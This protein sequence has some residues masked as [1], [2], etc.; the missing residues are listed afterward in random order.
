M[1]SVDQHA[2]SSSSS[3]FGECE[4][5]IQILQLIHHHQQQRSGEEHQPE[6]GRQKVAA[7]ARQRMQLKQRLQQAQ[8]GRKSQMQI[9]DENLSTEAGSLFPTLN[10]RFLPSANGGGGDR[11]GLALLERDPLLQRASGGFRLFVHKFTDQQLLKCMRTPALNTLRQWAPAN[12]RYIHVFRNAWK[13]LTQFERLDWQERFEHYAKNGQIASILPG[14][15][16]DANAAL[17][18]EGTSSSSSCKEDEQRLRQFQWLSTVDADNL[19]CPLCTFE[20]PRRYKIGELLAHLS[21]SH[22]SAHLYACHCCSR[23]FTRVEA[24]KEHGVS[25]QCRAFLRFMR[26]NVRKM[27]DEVRIDDVILLNMT[28]HLFLKLIFDFAYASLT[29]A[30]CG[31]HLLLSPRGDQD[32]LAETLLNITLSHSS[33]SLALCLTFASVELT[34]PFVHLKFLR[35]VVFESVYKCEFCLRSGCWSTPME[36]E[37]HCATEHRGAKNIDALHKCPECS[38]TFYTAPLFCDHLLSEHLRPDVGALLITQFLRT[39]PQLPPALDK[40]GTVLVGTVGVRRVSSH[41]NA[42][43]ATNPLKWVPAAERAAREGELRRSKRKRKR[44]RVHTPAPDEEEGGEAEDDDDDDEDE[45]DDDWDE[46]ELLEAKKKCRSAGG[47][48]TPLTSSS[49]CSL[50]AALSS[51]FGHWKTKMRQLEEKAFSADGGPLAKFVAR[52]ALPVQFISG[53]IIAHNPLEGALLTESVYQCVKCSA[54][55]SGESAVTEHIIVCHQIEKNGAGHAGA[56]DDYEQLLNEYVFD[57]VEMLFVAGNFPFTRIRCDLCSTN[58]CSIPSLRRHYAQCH[59]ILCAFQ[60]NQSTI[61]ECAAVLLRRDWANTGFDRELLQ[62]I[63]SSQPPKCTSEFESECDGNANLHQL[64]AVKLSATTLYTSLLHLVEQ[65]QQQPKEQQQE[66]QRLEVDADDDAGVG[67]IVMDVKEEPME[68]EEWEQEHQQHQKLVIDEQQSEAGQT[69]TSSSFDKKLLDDAS[70]F[71][72]ALVKDELIEQHEEQESSECFL[73]MSKDNDDGDVGDLS[74]LVVKDE[75]MNPASSPSSHAT[76]ADLLQRSDDIDSDCQAD[77]EDLV[78]HDHPL[79]QNKKRGRKK[80]ETGQGLADGGRHDQADHVHE[81]HNAYEQQQLADQVDVGDRRRPTKEPVKWCCSPIKRGRKKGTGTTG[82]R[83]RPRKLVA[84]VPGVD[85]KTM[86]MM[87]TKNTKTTTA[88]RKSAGGKRGRKKKKKAIDDDEWMTATAR[89]KR[90]YTKRKPKVATFIDEK[91]VEDKVGTVAAGTASCTVATEAQKVHEEGK[92]GKLNEVETIM[93]GMERHFHRKRGRPAKKKGATTEQQGP[94]TSSSTSTAVVIPSSSNFVCFMCTAV[95]KNFDAFGRHLRLH[96]EQWRRC[97]ICTDRRKN[98]VEVEKEAEA[99]AEQQQQDKEEED[100]SSNKHPKQRQR[101]YFDHPVQ[102]LKHLIEFHMNFQNDRVQCPWCDYCIQFN[103]A[104]QRYRASAAMFRHMV[105]ECALSSVCLLCGHVCT[106]TTT[107]K[108]TILPSSSTSLVDEKNMNEQHGDGGDQQ[109]DEQ[110]DDGG[111]QQQVEQHGDRVDGGDQQ[112]VEQHGDSV[113]GGDQQQV[114][115][116]GDRVDGGD[117]QQVEQHGDRV[118]GGDQ[119]QVE[120]HG[121]CV[122]GGDQQHVEQR[123]DRVDGGDQQ[124]KKDLMTKHRL[125]K[126]QL[127]FDRFICFSCKGGFYSREQFLHHTCELALRC[128]CNPSYRFMTRADYSLHLQKNFKHWKNHGLMQAEHELDS[129]K[130]KCVL[131]EDYRHH[132]GTLEVRKREEER[133]ARGGQ[134]GGADQEEGCTVIIIECKCTITTTNKD[135]ANRCAYERKC[136]LNEDYRHHVDT[137]EVRKREEDV[138]RE[139]AKAVAQIKKAVPSSSSSLSANAPPPPPIKMMPIDAVRVPRHRMMPVV[140]LYSNQSYERKCVLNEDYRHHV[141]TL[142]VRKRE[143]DAE[144]EATKAEVHITKAVLSSLSSANASSP[145]PP[146]KMMPIDAVRVPRHRLMPVVPLDSYR[147]FVLRSLEA[148][149]KS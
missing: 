5:Q 20:N 42:A 139:A 93:K 96:P 74:P 131:N 148:K 82:L 36:L 19:P 32:E 106:T 88:V 107:A 116:H 2:S 98:H 94:T 7:A 132:V 138:E 136:V 61:Q 127:I 84:G 123:G 30:E 90:A 65:Q 85:N 59:G 48:P 9:L 44:R 3:S 80:K 137:L 120:Q 55:I 129:G 91:L 68:E 111:D 51:N 66:E 37:R 147:S 8:Q 102:F 22:H 11:A 149:K 21:L 38:A 67:Q 52:L 41:A 28:C 87:L 64:G 73:N 130:R 72:N 75:E 1:M 142:E 33:Q 79:T 70:A 100:N 135:D 39:V 103:L 109:Q 141:G 112:Q 43:A 26:E 113:D 119:Q 58:C 76:F 89:P 122:D 29:C 144:R 45:F 13:K 15:S 145:P 4:F 18:L 143:E 92:G 46:D 140:P 71:S 57:N 83:G 53:Q 12:L 16:V 110:H 24:L 25:G 27:G 99:E 54:I 81:K 133:R 40:S 50:S 126:H 115:Q 86:A 62:Q 35:P 56:D 17:L 128:I 121:D 125:E 60:R 146:I 31:L 14:I 108:T 117:Q 34:Q 6:T 77:H 95:E 105:Y 101:R 118:D 63:N 49:S 69:P 78:K 47:Q 10:D 114:E 134:S 104:D 23:G 124:P 97:T